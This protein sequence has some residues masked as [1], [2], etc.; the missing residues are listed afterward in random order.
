MDSEQRTA[1]SKEHGFRAAHCKHADTPQCTYNGARHRT[2]SRRD[3]CPGLVPLKGRQCAARDSAARTITCV[4]CSSR[5]HHSYRGH[6]LR[7][8]SKK[9]QCDKKRD[10]NIFL[11]IASESKSGRGMKKA[12]GGRLVQVST[13]TPRRTRALVGGRRGGVE[14]RLWGGG[15]ID[16][17]GW[18]R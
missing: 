4:G 17:R 14:E 8:R 5:E 10:A 7:P 6:R 11:T 2:A 16:G 13:W 15:S 12:P 9:T 1:K 18:V 3:A